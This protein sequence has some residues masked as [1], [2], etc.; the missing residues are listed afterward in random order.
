[1]SL[2][3]TI[4]LIDLVDSLSS[5]DL[6]GFT[7]LGGA[8]LTGILLIIKDTILTNRPDTTKEQNTVEGHEYF[9]KL[10]KRYLVIN[11]IVITLV[12]LAPPKEVSYTLLAAYGVETTVQALTESEEAQRIASKSLQV[13]EQYMDT[14]LQEESQ[15]T[16]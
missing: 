15:Q 12:W 8:G 1:M 7:L 6:I 5:G 4:Y 9:L 2:V 10:I 16:E 11:T 14:Y 13:I 3:L